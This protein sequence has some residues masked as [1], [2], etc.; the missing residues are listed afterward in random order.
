MD[1]SK[2]KQYHITPVAK[3]RMTQQDKWKKRPC[4]VKYYRFKDQIKL[5]NIKLKDFG[6]HYVFILP[7]PK[8]WSNKKKQRMN[9][10]PHQ[11]I[12]DSDNIQKALWDACLKEDKGIFDY[13]CSKYWGYIGY[14]C[15]GDI[16][17][18]CPQSLTILNK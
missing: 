11:S 18:C 7:M 3:P 15:I 14:I 13:R 6:E 17:Y 4:V 1:L 5:S 9:G 2:F 8:S 10:V 12:R 16:Q